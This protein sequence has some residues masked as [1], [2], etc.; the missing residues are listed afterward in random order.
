MLC[1]KVIFFIPSPETC[2]GIKND[3]THIQKVFATS[4]NDFATK[5]VAMSFLRV[6]RSFYW[7]TRSFLKVAMSSKI[8]DI[9]TLKMN[10]P[11]LGCCGEKKKG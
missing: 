8:K 7:M 6:A 9:A 5:N 10:L 11:Q 2:H 3:L 4:K 1:G